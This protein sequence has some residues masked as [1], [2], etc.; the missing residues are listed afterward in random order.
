MRKHHRHELS[1]SS[2]GAGLASRFESFLF[3]ALEIMSRNKLQQLKKDC[4]TMSH[5]L[6]LLLFQCVIGKHTIPQ[7]AELRLIYCSLT[8]QLCYLAEVCRSGAKI[9]SK[10]NAGSSDKDKSN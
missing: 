1:P 4:S 6:I 2:K 7:K 9:V 5:G 8:G 3:N 10:T